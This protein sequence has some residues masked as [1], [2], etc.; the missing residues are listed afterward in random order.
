MKSFGEQ[1]RQAD[2]IVRVV[3]KETQVARA[4]EGVTSPIDSMSAKCEVVE[5]YKGKP[6]TD[7]S[8]QIHCER[9]QPEFALIR[10]DG[11]YVVIL[12]KQSKG[13]EGSSPPVKAA[14]QVKDGK[15]TDPENKGKEITLEELQK[16]I[17][18]HDNGHG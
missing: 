18:G 7:K 10:K 17:R 8:V 9:K 4:S 13:D 16:K 15:V 2:A 11:E 12:G 3:V 5:Q 6:G 14:Y 1:V